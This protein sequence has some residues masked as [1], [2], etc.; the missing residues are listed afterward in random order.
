MEGLEVAFWI[1]V[2][3]VGYPYLGYPLLLWLA[4]PLGRFWKALRRP[5]PEP[6]DW[7]EVTLVI[8]AYREADS[9]IPKMESIRALDYPKDRLRILWI[10]ATHEGDD[11]LAPTLEALQRYPE[12]EYHLVPH[13]GK[14]YS[15]NYARQL[16]NS[17]YTLLT[18]ADITLSPQSLREAM[19]LA[20]LHPKIGLV[21]GRRTLN[22]PG[23]QDPIQP[24]EKTYLSYD[25]TL[26]R[27][28]G[29]Q[30]Y[31]LAVTGALLL[32][33]TSLWPEMPDRVVDDLYLYLEA[34]LK[35]YYTLFAPGAIVY[36]TPSAS[37]A[38]EFQRKAR[39]AYTAFYTLRARLR[40]KEALRHPTFTFF[41]VSHKLFR[42][43]LAPIGLLGTLIVSGGLSLSGNYLYLLAFCVQIL[44]WLQ[45]LVMRYQLP[46]ALP[47]SLYLPGYFI[48]AHLA[49][50]V[51]FWKFLRGED[52][53][54]VWQRLPRAEL[55]SLSK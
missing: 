30:G 15:L 13:K 53:R 52:P 35:G 39:I 4:Q 38:V 14:I 28:E 23:E 47:R 3:L 27:L 20:L 8:P 55:P 40:W 10:I 19:R 45:A 11:S 29:I 21:S 2:A 48:L 1:A 6:T 17:P 22:Q 9:V 34:G 16:V 26:A 32:M 12:A 51:G 50:L 46:R 42:Y 18:D 7:P 5:L 33:P 49:Q 54:K 37:S 25:Q 36:E 41:L 31:A 24:S 44:A 43:L